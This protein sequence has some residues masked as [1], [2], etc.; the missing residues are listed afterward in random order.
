MCSIDEIK[1]RGEVELSSVSRFEK[2]ING[3]NFENLAIKAYQ[4]SA[5]DK[6]MND[7]SKI[8]P[9]EILLKCV[10]YLRDCIVDLDRLSDD[11]NP[12]LSSNNND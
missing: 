1:Q 3:V 8:R 7:P 2:D 12:Y 5:A 6:V 10:E 9:P 4:R 11:K